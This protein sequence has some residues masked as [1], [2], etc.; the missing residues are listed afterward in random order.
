MDGTSY[1]KRQHQTQ[2]CCCRLE[3]AP[4]AVSHTLFCPMSTTTGVESLEDQQQAEL[5]DEEARRQ[6]EV[7]LSSLRRELAEVRKELAAKVGGCC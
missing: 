1:C 3:L 5:T 4:T 6:L 7:E 2:T